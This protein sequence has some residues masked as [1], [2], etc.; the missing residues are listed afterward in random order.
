ME[1]WVPIKGFEGLY[2]VSNLGRVKSLPKKWIAGNNTIR[3][4]N[5]KILKPSY[6]VK[7]NLGYYVV[8]LYKNRVRKR[9]KVHKLVAEH[10]LPPPTKERNLLDHING[11]KK[12][13]RACNLRWVNYFENACS[14]LNT[15]TTENKVIK[16]YSLD[17]KLLNQYISINEAARQTGLNQGNISHCLLGKYKTCGGF[18]W[19]YTVKHV[20]LLPTKEN[21]NIN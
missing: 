18:V 5:G 13:N 6:T 9:C 2:E 19:K 14:N 17:G 20:G 12:D 11:N 3:Q 7:G 10:F 1:I 16:Q 8:L 4:H 15:P 21:H